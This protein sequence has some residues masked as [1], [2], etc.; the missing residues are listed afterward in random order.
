M[1]AAAIYVGV[2]TH[3]LSL[4]SAACMIVAALIAARLATRL[5]CSQWGTL[6]GVAVL[7][8]P[9]NFYTGATVY[10]QAFATL[11][12]VALWYT[13]YEVID[14]PSR[15]ATRTLLLF[16]QLGI[17]ASMLAL[18]VPVLAATG[19]IV[20]VLAIIFA[21]HRRLTCALVSMAF[22]LTPITAWMLRNYVSLGH[23]VPIST[24]T[25]VNLLIGNNENATGS[26]GLAADIGEARESATAIPTE[27]GRDAYFRDLAID[28]ISSHPV[29]AL[30]LFI[31]KTLNYFAPYNEPVTASAGS[32]TQR[33]VA[34]V[35]FASLVGLVAVRFYLRSRQPFAKSEIIL[36]AIYIINAPIMAVFFTRVRFRQPLDTILILEAS[37]AIVVLINLLAKKRLATSGVK[38]I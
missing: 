11:V 15:S 22:F 4:V 37:V 2:P 9:L 7:A 24:S 32:E 1:L 3:L 29:D 10:P 19:G 28:W 25:G 26:S 8:Y 36:V 21:S 23:I 13:M 38:E 20:L 6:A 30:T 34:Y 17:L 27:P 16:A 35:S 31:A 12:V 5:T 14:R 33:L 18:S